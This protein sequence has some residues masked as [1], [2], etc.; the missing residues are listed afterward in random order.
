M[1][2][3]FSQELKGGEMLAVANE[4]GAISIH[5]TAKALGDFHSTHGS[6]CALDNGKKF[7]S[8]LQRKFKSI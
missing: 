5:N 6:I 7:E 2:I 3:S 8:M 1:S 4:N